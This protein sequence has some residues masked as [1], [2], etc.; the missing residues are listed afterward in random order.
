MIY[1]SVPA[2]QRHLSEHGHHPFYMVYHDQLME[3]GAFQKWEKSPVT[4]E[5]CRGQA[6]EGREPGL[7]KKASLSPLRWK[8]SKS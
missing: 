4:K 5:L 7:V 3:A 6:G 1:D 8:M 2:N